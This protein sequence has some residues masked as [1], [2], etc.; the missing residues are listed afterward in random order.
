[1]DGC[2]WMLLKSFKDLAHC[3]YY[4]ET[5]QSNRNGKIDLTVSINEII[6]LNWFISV[7]MKTNFLHSPWKHIRSNILLYF[8]RWTAAWW[9]RSFGRVMI[10]QLQKMTL[11]Q[12]TRTDAYT[13][14]LRVKTLDYTYLCSYIYIALF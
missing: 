11:V 7:Q 13:N 12:V 6:D 1:M 9:F 5:S 10:C 8:F 14:C 4:K 3:Y 2:F